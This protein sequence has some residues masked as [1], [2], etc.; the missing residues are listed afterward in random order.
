MN[1]QSSM[2]LL[3]LKKKLEGERKK[4]NSRP[5]VHLTIQEFVLRDE[6]AI[7]FSPQEFSLSGL[8]VHAHVEIAGTQAQIAKELGK[9]AASRLLK[10]AASVIGK[11]KSKNKKK[12][13]SKEENSTLV[14][15]QLSKN[16]T[17]IDSEEPLGSF[18]NEA[19]VVQTCNV[20]LT[21]SMVKQ[22][23]N[24]KVSVAISELVVGQNS[25]ASPSVAKKALNN[26]RITS[27]IE[28]GI[29][30]VV[31]KKLKKAREGVFKTLCCFCFR[32]FKSS[33]VK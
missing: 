13:G 14:G 16:D 30:R 24:E 25:F 8:Q 29:A 6:G 20:E 12:K 18:D 15:K 33:P 1:V 32:C 5:E 23:G 4:V 17:P 10:K 19:K 2:S 28:S 3:M 26:P 21:L 9:E 11:G 22:A 7:R 27:L 31:T